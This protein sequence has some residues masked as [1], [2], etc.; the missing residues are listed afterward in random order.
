MHGIR[1]YAVQCPGQWAYAYD[2]EKAQANFQPA[3]RGRYSLQ[4][5]HSHATK[6]ISKPDDVW[7]LISLTLFSSTLDDQQHRRMCAACMATFFSIS[8]GCGRLPDATDAVSLP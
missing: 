1:A 6:A 4:Y 8:T 7:W 2:R 3:R 5:S